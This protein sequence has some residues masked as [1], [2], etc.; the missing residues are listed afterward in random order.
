M[1][2]DFIFDGKS[3]SDFNLMICEIN[4]GSGINSS[5]ISNTKFST[6]KP[7][8]SDRHFFTGS[9]YDYVL[10]KTI[11]VCKIGCDEDN[12]FSKATI[13]TT[14]LL[15]ETTRAK[16]VEANLQSQII[17]N[18]PIWDDK[19]TKNEVDNKFSVLETNIDWKESVNTYSEIVITY[20]NPQDGWTVNVKDTDYTYRFTGSEWVAI[21][22]NAIP[23]A[24]QTID[25]LLSKDDKT[26]YDDANIKKHIHD[27][28][29]LIDTINDS[30]FN[31]ID[32]AY[33]H[34]QT[35]II[36]ADTTSEVT[37][38]A[39]DNFTVVDG[40]LRDVNGHVET[41]NTKTI[42]LPNTPV[43]VDDT[44]SLTS[45]N[46]VQ[47]KVI[48]EKFNS[49]LLD[50]I[51]P[52]NTIYETTDP[53]FNPNTFWGGSWTQ[54]KDKFLLSSGNAYTSGST[55]GASTIIL[56]SAQLPSHAHTISHTH[57][58]NTGSITSSGAHTHTT[59]AKSTSGII[60]VNGAVLEW[61]DTRATGTN[62]TICTTGHAD[63]VVNIP[64][65][66]IASS[67]AHT[68]TVPSVSTK[69]ISTTSSGSVGSSSS[70]NNMPP[71]IVINV[72]KRIS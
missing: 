72:W 21:S 58:T 67:G 13:N 10:T 42:T 50:Y 1:R 70:H 37:P 54:I 35:A 3:A 68:H 38:S 5:D 69:S 28:K 20:P 25:G 9:N 26:N 19:Y 60:S 17:T 45:E 2:D 43:I 71:Y 46:P 63:V 55:G 14:N 53:D 40:I 27:N 7:V 47:N 31:K 29:L 41:I 49:F 62:G 18:K 12:Y 16:D 15:S 59:T 48:T 64:S 24:T 57:N 8:N 61:G 51:Y 23:K 36:E 39:G 33:Q 52:I 65:L 22:A 11:Q 30:T 44:L 34:S 4:K 32:S 6:F 66:S 56:T